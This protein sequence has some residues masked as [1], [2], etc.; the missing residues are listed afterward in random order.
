MLFRQDEALTR[1]FIPVRDYGRGNQ[2]PWSA[3][4]PDFIPHDVYHK[5]TWEIANGY[6]VVYT[7]K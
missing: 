5:D 1:F 3:G 6:K 4:S 7:Q 2:K